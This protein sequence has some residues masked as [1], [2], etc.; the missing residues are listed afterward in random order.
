MKKKLNLL[1]MLVGLLALGLTFIGCPTDSDD[2]DG[3]GGGGTSITIKNQ[4]DVAITE[5]SITV[6]YVGGDL[7]EP[8]KT[9]IEPGATHEFT[10]Q[11]E[12]FTVWVE[13][14]TQYSSAGWQSSYK[15]DNPDNVK[16]PITLIFT[17]DAGNMHLTLEK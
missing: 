12:E 13:C 9:P 11:G 3:G 4:S 10:I 14:G 7:I 8:Y 15:G 1:V 5:V 6:P 17:I 16:G 2:D